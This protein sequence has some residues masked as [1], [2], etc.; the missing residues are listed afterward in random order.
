[1]GIN[2]RLKHIDSGVCVICGAELKS[3]NFGYKHCHGGQVEE[4]SYECGYAIK[5]SPNL[6]TIGILHDCPKSPKAIVEKEAKESLKT[7]L[8]EVVLA[9][10]VSQSIKERLIYEFKYM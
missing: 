5:Y 7:K 10:Q 4:V 3:V 8:E 6:G 1:M 2:V 9:S